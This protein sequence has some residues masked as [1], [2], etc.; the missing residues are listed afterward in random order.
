MARTTGTK[1]TPGAMEKGQEQR[2]GKNSW[3]FGGKE[4][5]ESKADN[6]IQ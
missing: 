2:E 5:E 4:E 1:K 3:R 6:F